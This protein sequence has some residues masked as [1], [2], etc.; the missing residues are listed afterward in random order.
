MRD[1]MGLY[2]GKRLDGIWAEGF[3]L[4]GSGR[5]WITTFDGDDGE[6]A[7]LTHYQ[8]DPAT[9]G[10]WTGL[11]DRNGKRIFEG[12]IIAVPDEYPFFVDGKPNYVGEVEWIYSAWQYVLRCV[13]P[14]VR[15]ISDGIN[16]GLNDEG[17]DEGENTPFEIIGNVHDHDA[18]E[19]GHGSN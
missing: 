15:G 13:N 1:N 2:R 16:H 7:D 14:D 10:Q 18:K 9:V 3:L 11:C 8:V 6:N 12:D 5:A 17:I 19:G 4:M